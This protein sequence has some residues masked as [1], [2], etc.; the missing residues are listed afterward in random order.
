MLV[1]HQFSSKL[2][3]IVVIKYFQIVLKQSFKD[4]LLF[5][6]ILTEIIFLLILRD[7]VSII[8]EKFS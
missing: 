4:Y 1:F 5:L 7:I 2:F 8:L 3:D 6:R